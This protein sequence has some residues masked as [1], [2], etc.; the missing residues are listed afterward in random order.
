M[1]LLNRELLTRLVRFFYVP[2]LATFR[3]LISHAVAVCGILVGLPVSYQLL[4][5][6]PV[7]TPAIGLAFTCVDSRNL[8]RYANEAASLRAMRG[9]SIVAQLDPILRRV[10][11]SA[12]DQDDS[13][14]GEVLDFNS[15]SPR[16]H[17][18]WVAAIRPQDNPFPLLGPRFLGDE[19]VREELASGQFRGPPRIPQGPALAPILWLEQLSESGPSSN[20]TKWPNGAP[21]FIEAGVLERE[22]DT[23]DA[24]TA[25]ILRW[26]LLRSRRTL[27]LISFRNESEER[28]VRFHYEV[29]SAHI[30]P[31]GGE[32]G[33][34]SEWGVIRS[35]DRELQPGARSWSL[36]ETRGGVLDPSSTEVV[37]DKSPFVSWD[38]VHVWL[39]AALILFAATVVLNVFARYAT[40]LR[41]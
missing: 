40:F 11:A 5:S 22:I 35:S 1:L 25:S 31:L 20:R 7:V 38:L 24:N 3:G 8:I 6:R 2:D 14:V 12:I 37:Y 4:V 15:T 39:K 32:T 27:N 17:I 18:C 13:T 29:N 23:I 16:I 9:V 21:I 33:A 26:G 10:A 41:L 19:T 28:P 30:R 34:D 36:L